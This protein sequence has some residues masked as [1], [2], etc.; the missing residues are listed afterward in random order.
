MINKITLPAIFGPGMWDNGLNQSRYMARLKTDNRT[1]ARKSMALLFIYALAFVRR[2]AAERQLSCQRRSRGALDCTLVKLINQRHPAVIEEHYIAIAEIS[3]RCLTVAK[4]METVKIAKVEIYVVSQIT[5]IWECRWN[6]GIN[7]EEI[8]VAADRVLDA[9][10]PPAKPVEDEATAANDDATSDH[11][12]NDATSKDADS[13]TAEEKG[14]ASANNALRRWVWDKQD[15]EDVDALRMPSFKGQS[16]LAEDTEQLER[17]EKGI[18]LLLKGR[19]IWR[20]WAIWSD[21]ELRHAIAVCE[22]LHARVA[23]SESTAETHGKMTS[24]RLAALC[25]SI[26]GIIDV[27]KEQEELR[28]G[29]MQLQQEMDAF[30]QDMTAER[31]EL[32]KEVDELQEEKRALLSS[33]LQK[34]DANAY[35]A[36]HAAQ[37]VE[38]KVHD[39]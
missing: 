10:K 32:Q 31:S 12:A 36:Y 28:F 33:R 18:N 37:V 34:H 30:K 13:N 20:E 16:Q 35:F 26:D 29:E 21:G 17:L 27:S 15:N 25:R 7:W 3:V 2:S 19:T 24:L 39:G 1:M 5:E 9:N 4:P 8:T 22:S 6:H 11:V 23:A 38:A 14:D